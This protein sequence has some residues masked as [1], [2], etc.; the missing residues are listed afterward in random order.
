MLYQ[1]KLLIMKKL[2]LYL[3][4][5]FFVSSCLEPASNDSNYGSI[6]SGSYSSILAVGDYLYAVNDRELSTF[7]IKDESNPIL[8]D[9]QNVG[10]LIENI[11]YTDGVLF[12]GSKGA[13]YIFAINEK[14]IPVKKSETNYFNAEGVTSCDPVIVKNNYAYVTLSTVTIQNSPCFRQLNINELR[15]YD[16]EDIE[17]PKL[18]SQLS[19]ESPKGLAFDNEYLFVCLAFRGIAV[20]D[21][22]DKTNPQILQILEKFESYD[23]IATNGLLMVVC[24][25]EIREYDYSDINNIKYLNSLKL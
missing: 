6:L 22:S 12:L 24:P 17:N 1:L 15:V 14:G 4:V 18:L 20:I 7:D 10:F 21:V 16:V 8:L 11:Y 25:T 9:K 23:V 13:L 3:F 2:F 5:F 19:L